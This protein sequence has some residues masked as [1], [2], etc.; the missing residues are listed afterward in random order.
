M[1]SC[2][3]F[4]K[5]FKGS[6]KSQRHDFHAL[7]STIRMRCSTLD[8]KGLGDSPDIDAMQNFC[9]ESFSLSSQSPQWM[10]ALKQHAR[11]SIGARMRFH[12]EQVGLSSYTSLSALHQSVS[13]KPVL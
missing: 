6:L 2:P 4:S 5:A 3:S 13:R 11:Y 9:V 1:S 8:C 10:V 12:D 7:R